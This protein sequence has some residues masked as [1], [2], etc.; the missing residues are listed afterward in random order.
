M[1]LLVVEDEQTVAD[2]L[3]QLLQQERY[4]CDVRNN[5]VQ[6]TLYEVIRFGAFMVQ[7]ASPLCIGTVFLEDGS[8]VYGFLCESDAIKDAD[9]ITVFGGW[10][11][12][13]HSK[14]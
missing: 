9:E 3:I 11:A 6:H 7:I 4:T 8:S 14:Q 5:F 13:L 12:Y 2:Q 1:H 10:R